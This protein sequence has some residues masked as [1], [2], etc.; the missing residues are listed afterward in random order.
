MRFKIV[1]IFGGILAIYRSDDVDGDRTHIV[2]LNPRNAVRVK[3]A[4]YYYTLDEVGY[5][6]IATHP[7]EM[8]PR[9]INN[10]AD[11]DEFEVK[12]AEELAAYLVNAIGSAKQMSR[13]FKKRL[14]S[15]LVSQFYQYISKAGV[16]VSDYGDV[17]KASIEQI[18]FANPD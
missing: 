2:V 3:G 5:D 15:D 13:R 1:S 10:V 18:L 7:I 16:S 17:Q 12:N 9:G 4:K 8:V 11:Q 6:L 14:A